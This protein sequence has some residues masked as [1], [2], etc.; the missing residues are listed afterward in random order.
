VKA[1]QATEPDKIVL[2]PTLGGSLPL[3]VFEKYLQTSPVTIPI[4]NYDNNQHAENENIR[5]KN[6]KKG[7][8]SFASIMCLQK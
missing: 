8:E 3:Y 5:I 7:I 1:V 4:A 6:F 2:T